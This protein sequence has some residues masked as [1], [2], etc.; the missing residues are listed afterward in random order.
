MKVIVGGVKVGPEWE[1]V[2]LS[3]IEV[4]ASGIKVRGW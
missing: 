1:L 2:G 3:R 4:R